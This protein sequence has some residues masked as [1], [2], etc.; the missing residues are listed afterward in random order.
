[1]SRD[2]TQHVPEKHFPVNQLT[3]RYDLARSAVYTRLD[4]L[5]IKPEKVGNRAYLNHAQLK[6]M[7]ELHNFIQTGGQTAAFLEKKGLKKT[8]NALP[9]SQ[10]GF[11]LMQHPDIAQ[12]VVAM[13]TELARH[14]S[15]V[16][17]PGPLAHFQALEQA[18]QCGWLL[19][20]SEITQLLNFP[21]DTL[22]QKQNS[23][24]EAGFIFTQAGHRATGEIAWK[25]SKPN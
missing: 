25:V 22:P 6:L 17:S 16:M 10:A 2:Q 19:S 14:Q 11:P 15:S 18:V 1:M 12:L 23:F 20:T 8:E 13:S 21:P 9:P 5:G 4:A 24:T 7:D 3:Q